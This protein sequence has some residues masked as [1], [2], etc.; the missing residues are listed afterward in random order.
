MK[1]FIFSALLTLAIGLTGVKSITNTNNYK[2]V[3]D[4]LNE[5]PSESFVYTQKNN[6]KKEGETN[7]DASFLSYVTNRVDYYNNQLSIDLN[8]TLNASV[9]GQVVKLGD[10]SDLVDFEITFKDKET[11]Q[12]ITD[13]IKGQKEIT[14]TLDSSNTRYN[15]VTT[16]D[17]YPSNG[18]VDSIIIKDIYTNLNSTKDGT[19]EDIDYTVEY[20]LSTDEYIETPTDTE[21]EQVISYS[22]RSTTLTDYSFNFSLSILFDQDEVNDIYNDLDL[23]VIYTVG[24][25]GEDNYY[26]AQLKVT[27]T[28]GEIYYGDLQRQTGVSIYAAL[29]IYYSQSLTTNCCVE[30]PYQTKKSDIANIELVNVFFVD[31]V[32]KNKEYVI[33]PRF[34]TNYSVSLDINNTSSFNRKLYTQSDF[35]EI[36]ATNL[37]RFG[38]IDSLKMKVDIKLKEAYD[39]MFEDS[40]FPQLSLNKAEI[41]EKLESGEYYYRAYFLFSSFSEE[42]KEGS[43]FRILYND[44]SIQYIGASVSTTNQIYEGEN[45]FTFFL[46]DLKDRE[47]IKSIDIFG[48]TLQYEL[49]NAENDSTISN[50]SVQFKFGIQSLN[51]GN[52]YDVKGTQIVSDNSIPYI[53]LNLVYV[54]FTVIYVI[55]FIAGTVILFVILS[56]KFKDD[57]F[58]RIKPKSFFKTAFYALLCTYLLISDFIIIGF[59]TSLFNNSV[60]VT[61]IM[62]IMIIVYTIAGGLLTGYF[63]RRFYISIKDRMEKN[64]RE[65]LKLDEKKEDSSGVDV[66]ANATTS[67]KK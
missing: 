12:S 57:E 59:R 50:S 1:N 41:L 22:V 56:K 26:P 7:L 55:L 60:R 40:Y 18:L 31:E 25:Y 27:L 47:N 4:A 51:Y 65:K 58:R 30:V 23:K 42:R 14:C 53:D 19:L 62:D 5:T 43:Y 34:N 35:M 28:N 64:K 39:M 36:N 46:E 54:L 49:A 24:Y 63:I 17:N 29:G 9:D 2:N 6:V 3:D 10:T 33:E 16:F 11:S 61:N 66:T 52:S 67:R 48:I 21:M 38:Q 15:L 45:S 32:S 20:Q 8:L 44:D 13:T 37:S